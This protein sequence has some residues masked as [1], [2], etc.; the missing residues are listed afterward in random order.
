MT[1]DHGETEKWVRNASLL[2][3]DQNVIKITLTKKKATMQRGLFL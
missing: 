2:T 3:R 1:F